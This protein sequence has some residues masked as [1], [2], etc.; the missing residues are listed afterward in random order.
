MNAYEQ[1]KEV[2]Y[3]NIE[4]KCHG[5]YKR[6]AYFHS[7]QVC[8]LCQKMALDQNLNL[9]IAGIMGLFHDYSQFI[10]HSSFQHAHQSAE[11]LEKLFQETS[12]DQLE[13]HIIL[14]AIRNHSDK[15]RI[16]DVY[17][18]ILKDADVLAQYLEE[19]DRVF[20]VAYQQRLK[21]YL[22]SQI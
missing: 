6:R 18:E 7:I 22:S 8:S 21:K 11:M 20:K 9:E 10:N 14:T 13:Q 5:I 1:L 12:L 17:S 3:I 19:P 2:F 16:D 15:E 4:E